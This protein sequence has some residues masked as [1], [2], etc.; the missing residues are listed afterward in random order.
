MSTIFLKTVIKQHGNRKSREASYNLTSF[1]E[2]PKLL[3]NK[4][5]KTARI[6]AEHLMFRL[7]FKV[8]GVRVRCSKK[9][10]TKKMLFLKIITRTLCKVRSDNFRI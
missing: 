7:H 10:Q 1:Q 4:N 2:K 6:R 8:Y 9:N 3:K 5:N